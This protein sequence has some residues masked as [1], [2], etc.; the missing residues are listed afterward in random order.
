MDC[1]PRRDCTVRMPPHTGCRARMAHRRLRMGCK[2]RRGCRDCTPPRGAERRSPRRPQHRPRTGCRHRRGRRRQH[3]DYTGCT[4]H[5]ARNRLH[6]GCRDCTHHRGR[7]RRRRG[8]RDYR[9]RMPPRTGCMDCTARTGCRRRRGA[10]PDPDAAGSL[11]GSR[12][13]MCRPWRGRWW[14]PRA[15]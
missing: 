4:R 5:T 14:R 1:M 10:R 13:T 3:T 12:R 9:A 6:R 15:R 2:G 7:T 8:C 11:S